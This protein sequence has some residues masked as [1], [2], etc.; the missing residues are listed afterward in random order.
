MSTTTDNQTQTAT[1]LIVEM[2][3]KHITTAIVNA[4]KGDTKGKP[5]IKRTKKLTLSDEIR[6]CFDIERFLADAATNIETLIARKVEEATTAALEKPKRVRPS[7]KDKK[8]TDDE[9]TIEATV[10]PTVEATIEATVEPTVEQPKKKRAP[11][12]KEPTVTEE[13]PTVVEE[14]PIVVEEQPTV[15]EEQPT[16]VEEQPKK[17]R[18]LKKKE[19]TVTEEQPTVVEEQ[20][21]KKRAA[22]KKSVIVPDSDA[23]DSDSPKKNDTPVLLIPTES[24]EQNQDENEQEND[25]SSVNTSDFVKQG[26]S[27]SNE[28]EE[29]ELSEI[30]EE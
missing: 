13:Q 24:G 2:A 21:K 23:S 15:V 28:L 11:K 16:V 3:E 4:A 1:N 17:K 10:E 12:K 19:P 9:A 18:P 30:D 7:K 22:K 26:L 25:D 27:I 14:Q 8:I 6:G 5:I 29:D 20:P